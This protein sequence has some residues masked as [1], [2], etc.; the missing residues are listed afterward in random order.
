MSKFCIREHGW[1]D[2]GL[3]NLALTPIGVAWGW[4]CQSRDWSLGA[5]LGSLL[6]VLLIVDVLIM[7]R[8]A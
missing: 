5:M 3:A 6:L 2:A 4:F 1:M 7:V 8:R